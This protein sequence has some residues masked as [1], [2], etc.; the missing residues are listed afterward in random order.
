MTAARVLRSLTVADLDELVEVEREAAVVAFAHV[1]PQE[2][3]PFPVADVRARWADELD[4]AHTRC[5]AVLDGTGVVAGFAALR[6][7]ELLHFGTALSQW[8]TG[9]AG[10]A[11]DELLDVLREQ[12]C[13]RAWLRVLAENHRAIRFYERR[14]WVATGETSHSPF[15][16]YPL[17]LHYARDLA[18]DLP[19]G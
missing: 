13:A 9:L 1:F 19:T 15:A 18:D 11:H 14:G 16:P 10:R 3:H 5:F 4:D 12:G 17:L 2:T 8:G 6:G 7:D